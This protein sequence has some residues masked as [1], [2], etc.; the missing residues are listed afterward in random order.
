MRAKGS[1]KRNCAVSPTLWVRV[2]L[3]LVNHTRSYA[4]RLWGA[5]RAGKRLRTIRVAGNAMGHYT[6]FIVGR[7]ILCV[8]CCI[9]YAAGLRT[10]DMQT[11]RFSAAIQIDE[12]HYISVISGVEVAHER[13]WMLCDRYDE[14]R[15]RA[16]LVNTYTLIVFFCGCK[17]V[18]VGKACRRCRH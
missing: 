1:P 8:F 13:V 17:N 3:R 16:R 10:A 4:N 11:K 15:R 6:C 12:R 9:A 14:T 18:I 2:T 7:I 5:F